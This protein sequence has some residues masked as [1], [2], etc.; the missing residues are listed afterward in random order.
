MKVQLKN[1]KANLSMSDETLCFSASIYI[2]GKKVGEAMNHGCGGPTEYHFTDHTILESFEAY[3]KGL[4]SETIEIE[5][6]E[7]L[8]MEMNGEN[9][10]DTLIDEYMEAQEKKKMAKKLMGMKE[11]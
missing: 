2:D 8:T 9:L 10:I 1:V 11:E 4:P 7:P 3:A 5:G 6:Q